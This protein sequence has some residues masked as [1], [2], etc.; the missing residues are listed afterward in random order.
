MHPKAAVDFLKF[1]LYY[2]DTTILPTPVWFRGLRRPGD[3]VSITIDGKPHEIKLVSIGEGVGGV[4]HVVLSVDNIMHVFPVE[5]PEAALARKAIRK[6]DPAVKGEIA[7]PVTG[8]VWRIGT[9]DR[10]LKAG[11]RVKRGEEVMNIEVMKTENAVKSSL[12]G[13]IREICVKVNE[14]VEEGQLLAVIASG[15]E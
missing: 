8:T 11:D 15:G 3:S 9:K 13:V 4:K 1:R 6:A 10:I 2:G 12:P 7:A 5:L 14:G